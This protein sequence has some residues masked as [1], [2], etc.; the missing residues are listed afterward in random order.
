MQLSLDV[1]FTSAPNKSVVLQEQAEALV[2]PAHF[3]FFK[4]KVGPIDLPLQ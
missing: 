2:G 1:V 4:I 3:I